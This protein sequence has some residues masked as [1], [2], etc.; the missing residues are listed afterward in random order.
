MQAAFELVANI[1]PGEPRPPEF[2]EAF[3]AV[4]DRIGDLLDDRRARPR[5]DDLLTALAQ[6]MDSTDQLTKDEVVGNLLAI[7]SAG[8][9]TTS[10]AAT[11]MMTNLCKNREQLNEI[12]ADR[13][14]V[15][16]AVEESLRFQGPGLWTFARYATCDTEL[17][18][19]RITSGMPAPI[20]T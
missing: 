4:V 5:E 19:T 16:D 1:S 3:A 18:G 2:V 7:L 20:S 17:G 12:I 14:L 15:S 13:S 11:A 6:R 10:I 9:S 8:Q